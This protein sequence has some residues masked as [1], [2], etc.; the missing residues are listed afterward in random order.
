MKT[1]GEKF[2]CK[3]A[4]VIAKAAMLCA[5]FIPLVLA[6]ATAASSSSAPADLAIRNLIKA[7]VDRGTA[8]SLN[9]ETA[10]LFGF[11]RETLPVRKIVVL[12]QVLLVTPQDNYNSLLLFDSF[13]NG[14]QASPSAKHSYFFRICASGQV[15]V[16]L[17]AVDGNTIKD[18]DRDRDA[19]IHRETSHWL[20]QLGS[21]KDDNPHAGIATSTFATPTA[22]S[23][24]PQMIAWQDPSERA[25][26]VNVPRGWRISGGTVRHSPMDARNYVVA[27]SPDSKIR[28]WLNDPDVLPRQEPHP[29]YASIGWYEGRTVRGPGGPLFIERYRTGAQFAQDFSAQKLCRTLRTLSQ[30]DLRKESQQMNA[31][32]APAA[33]RAGARVQSNAGEVIYECGNQSGY[34]YSV[35][36][37]AYGNAQG[38]RIWTV[39]QLSGYVADRAE[40]NQARL[41]M[42]AMVSSFRIDPNWQRQYER[43]IRDTSGALMEI[44]NRI[45]QQSMQLAQQSLQQNTRQVQ[46]RQQQFDQ[47]SQMRED[48]FK[49]Q[50]DSQDRIRQRWSDTT[51]GQIHGCDDNGKCSTQS[52]DYQ[53]HWVAP[54]GSVVGGPSDGSSP[55]PGY[56]AWT[57]DHN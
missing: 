43:D 21:V 25:F 12:K 27:Q 30:F 40:I 15:L 46:Q 20:E 9:A 5:L 36:V 42:N 16:A 57:P 35:T 18:S 55:G 53:N 13:I 19:Q 28:V 26:T 48:S 39:E 22:I 32:I 23:A 8:S 24:V 34:T 4:F 37:L 29:M 3:N 51:L 41:V 45:T 56:H 49:R 11:N 2:N 1:N 54:N 50:M 17:H 38:P 47:M 44:S 7:A 14:T 52:N 10:Q 6:E 31:A 33:A